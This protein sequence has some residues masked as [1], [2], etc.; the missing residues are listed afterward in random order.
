MTSKERVKRAIHWKHPDRVPILFF[1]RDLDR[2]DIQIAD[3][4]QH[5][6]G[7][8]GK[9]SEWGF[10]WEQADDTMGQPKSS[11]I[12]SWDQL[13]EFI[14]PVPHDPGRFQSVFSVHEHY[15]DA[16]LMASLVLSGFTVLTFLRGFS[17]TLQDLYVHRDRIET[18]LDL[19]FEFE[20]RVIRNVADTPADAVA[21]YDDWGDQDRLLI[22]PALWREIFKPR[23][24]E[25][26]RIAHESGVDVYF[27]SCGYIR[28]IIPD[29]IEI[30]VDLLNI[31]QPN[32]YDIEALGRDHGG[33][34][35]F[36]CPVSYQ[37]TSIT[38]TRDDIF[39]EA[40][41]LV[42]N[43]GRPDGGFIGYVEAYES[44]GLSQ[45]NYQNCVDAFVELGQYSNSSGGE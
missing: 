28:E 42:Q 6:G 16:Y 31:S 24:K 26:F 9:Q 30:G 44:I 14:P 23:Y 12:R 22:S 11:L 15:P 35:C 20:T 38:G 25:Q 2:S 3:V 40:N 37:T 5:F 32:L 36:V 7:P 45:Q 17:E 27:H 33:D 18:L 34:V 13:H 8:D 29:L 4:V 1:N 43:L 21:F 10:E 41:R 39:R 19:I